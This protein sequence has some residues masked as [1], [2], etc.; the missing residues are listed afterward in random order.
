[1]RALIIAAAAVAMALALPSLAASAVV[2]ARPAVSPAVSVRGWGTNDDGE[3]GS[4][5]G[6]TDVLAPVKVKIPAGV[7][8][9]SIRAGCDHSVALTTTG[10]LLAWGSNALGQLGDGSFRRRNTPAQRRA[11][12]IDIFQIWNML[13]SCPPLP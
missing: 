4:G 10:A 11:A 6:A 9:T 8:V 5:S 2:T 7:T 3:L 12:R 1:M 13:A